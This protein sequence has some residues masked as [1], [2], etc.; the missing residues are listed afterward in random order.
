MKKLRLL[1]FNSLRLFDTLEYLFM[2]FAQNIHPTRLFGPTCLIDTW[3]NRHT[4]KS[5]PFQILQRCPWKVEN[6]SINY[7]LYF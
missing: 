6:A 2:R 5:I 7:L 4:K 3:E 1:L